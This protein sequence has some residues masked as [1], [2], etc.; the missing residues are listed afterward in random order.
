MF[1]VVS[2]AFSSRFVS[3]QMERNETETGTFFLSA[4]VLMWSVLVYRMY[5]IVHPAC[6]L[7]LATV[8]CH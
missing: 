5:Y 2:F 6:H 8:I 7:N 1:A 4:T 3:V